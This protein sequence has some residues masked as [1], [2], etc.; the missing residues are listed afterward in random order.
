[1][2]NRKRAGHIINGKFAK[3][4]ECI[5]AYGRLMKDLRGSHWH[6]AARDFS[7]QQITTS[8]VVSIEYVSK[9]DTT[10]ITTRNSIYFTQ[11]DVANIGSD[12][13]ITDVLQYFTPKGPIFKLTQSGVDMSGIPATVNMVLNPIFSDHNL[14][15]PDEK[16]YCTQEDYPGGLYQTVF[17]KDEDVIKC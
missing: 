9:T 17:L 16:P 2:E 14:C 1:M 10:I 6:G 13:V 11:G 4:G 12:K 7:G 8:Y 5:I 15:G 3:V